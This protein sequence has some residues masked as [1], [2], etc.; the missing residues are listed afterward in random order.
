MVIA[1]TVALTWWYWNRCQSKVQFCRCIRVG[2]RA[3]VLMF[4]VCIQV[5]RICICLWCSGKMMFLGR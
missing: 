4:D 3:S 2:G 1:V 5:L